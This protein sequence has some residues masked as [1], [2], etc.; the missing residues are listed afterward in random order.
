MLKEKE[1]ETRCMINMGERQCRYLAKIEN[2]KTYCCLKQT[3]YKIIIDST[4][5][6]N[7]KIKNQPQG[8]NCPGFY[9]ELQ[10]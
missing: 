6:E 1:L 2:E 9:V 4:L 3:K 7:K 10:T 8:D 5:K